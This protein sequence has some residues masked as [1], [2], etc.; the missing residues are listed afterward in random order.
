M[1]L[2][3]DVEDAEGVDFGEGYVVDAFELFDCEVGSRWGDVGEFPILKY[4]T[5]A[6]VE[7]WDFVL[8]VGGW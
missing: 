7:F 8:W 4:F 5:T 2:G 1:V 3:C 6:T